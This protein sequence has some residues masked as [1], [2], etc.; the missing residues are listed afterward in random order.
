MCGITGQLYFDMQHRVRESSLRTM[1]DTMVSRGPD[2]EGF[3]VDHNIGFGFRRLS[4]IDLHTGH[5]PLCNEDR[6]VWIVFN[7]EIFNYQE[8]RKELISRGHVFRT[9][10]DTETI[11]HAYEE[12]GRDCVTHLRGMF[13]FAI[14]DQKNKTLFCA[15]DRFGIKPFFYHLS[16]E[17]FVFGSE[18]KAVLAAGRVPDDLDY[19]ALDS[20]FAYQYVS[21]DLSIYQSIKKLPPSH[22][23]EINLST[24]KP[25]KTFTRYWD[26][27]FD[28]DE[29]KSEAQWC[30]E[31]D[32]MLTEAVRMR[33]ISDV[34]LGAFLS[35]GIDSSSVVALMARHSNY[36]IK[37]FSIGFKDARFNELDYARAVAKRYGTEHYEQIIEP[38][39][40]DLLPRLI[41]VYDEPFAD[42]SAIPTYY[43]SKFAREH[44]TVALSGDGGD[45]LFA[46]Y[47]TYSKLLSIR[48]YNILPNSVNRILWGAAHRCIPSRIKGHGLA[49]HLAQDRELVASYLTVWSRLERSRL[50]KRELAD[51]IGDHNAERYKE[52]LLR[53]S[54]SGDYLSRLQELDMRTFLVDDVLTKV[55]RVSMANS[56]EVRVPMLD[57]RLAE[58]SFRIPSHLKYK[59]GEKKY[60]LRKTMETSLPASVLSHKKQ[61][62]T[63]PLSAWFKG[64]L[65]DYVHERL[66]G[67]NNRLA[68]YVNMGYVR[69]IVMDNEKGMRT[70]YQKI[71]SLIVLDAWLEQ[72]ANRAGK[73][74]GAA[75]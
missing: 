27:H 5:Q 28:P 12:Y 34:P 3:Y 60:I 61:G 62:F 29:S 73:T 70:S 24:G 39:S 75:N 2:D 65:K 35:G 15:R 36:P 10:T 4:V 51:H 19:R 47:D 9:N 1:A 22:T 26:I 42:S 57:H 68:D 74:T 71:W 6:S 69:K 14:W 13:A 8:L 37:T 25:R 7:G 59:D 53:Q 64:S 40:V 18:I 23:L 63:I 33:M 58:L 56:L 49:Y 30:E 43:V 67:T 32:T 50:Y 48:K 46:G 41:N 31:L 21:D 20:Y 55:D 45:E 16:S 17:R 54:S 11:V 44:V 38:E 72:K 52:S 66:L